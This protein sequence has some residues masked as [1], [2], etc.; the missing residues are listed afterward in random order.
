MEEIGFIIYECEH[1]GILL[2]INGMGFNFYD[3]FWTPLYKARGLQWEDKEEAA[4]EVST[5]SS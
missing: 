5:A 1:C 4:E 3:A 2:G